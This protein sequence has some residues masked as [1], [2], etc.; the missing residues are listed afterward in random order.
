MKSYFKNIHVFYTNLPTKYK[1]STIIYVGGILTYNA[2][3]S[4]NNSK[5]YLE[6]Y[7]ADDLTNN[8]KEEV[9][10]E[11]DAVKFGANHDAFERFFNSLIF[12]ITITTNIIPM[13]VLMINKKNDIDNK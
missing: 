9:K 12:P 10:N 13:I 11:W 3:E 2:F 1:K 6:K 8:E 5:M 4:Y 7:R